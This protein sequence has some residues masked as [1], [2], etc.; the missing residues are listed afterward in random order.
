[1][2]GP[3]GH[4]HKQMGI[5]APGACE[6]AKRH[7][8]GLGTDLHRQDLTVA[9]IG[10]MSGDVFGNA[11]L[12]SPHIRLLGAFDHQHVFLDPN[13]DPAASYAE[14][15]RLFEL[16]QSSWNDYD[17]SLISSGGGVHDRNAKSIRISAE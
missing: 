1:S 8:R 4:D 10:D 2:G 9:A 5:T 3:H 12:R 17:R 15:R 13:P 7:F 11:M 6:S 14:R 16:S